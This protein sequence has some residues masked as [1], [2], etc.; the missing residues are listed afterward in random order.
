MVGATAVET[1]GV[2]RLGLAMVARQMAEALAVDLVV[3]APG[4]AVTAATVIA[5]VLTM[6]AVA[7]SGRGQPARYP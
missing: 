5:V 7:V 4:E 6:V 3:P 2:L 1:L